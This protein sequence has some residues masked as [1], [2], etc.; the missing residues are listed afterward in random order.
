M[1]IK[2]VT[3]SLE[4]N[5]GMKSSRQ[6]HHVSSRFKHFADANVT[7][8]LRARNNTR[9]IGLRDSSTREKV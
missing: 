9:T 3:Y 5:T 4:S 2:A 7:K 1:I 8:F 6:Q